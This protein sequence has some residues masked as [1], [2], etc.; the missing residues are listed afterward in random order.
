MAQRR[1]GLYIF[2]AAV[3]NP[4][5]DGGICNFDAARR[6]RAALAGHCGQNKRPGVATGPFA[7]L[8]A[9]RWT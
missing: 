1:G 8:D 3:G 5:M 6:R 7:F 4:F 9:E 2:R